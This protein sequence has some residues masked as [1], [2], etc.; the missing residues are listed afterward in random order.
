MNTKT[1]VDVDG[2]RFIV[3]FDA[4]GVPLRIKQRKAYGQYPIEGVY[5]APYWH[6][7]CH[8]LGKSKNTLPRRIIAA[9]EAKRDDTP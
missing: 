3:E 5:D 1:W 8:Q 4:D 7:K 6:A 9:A 2:R